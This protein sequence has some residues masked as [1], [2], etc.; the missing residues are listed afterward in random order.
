MLEKMCSSLSGDWRGSTA[1]RLQLAANP[2]PKQFSIPCALRIWNA[3][4]IK[5]HFAFKYLCH[6][7]IRK[8]C[9]L[10]EPTTDESQWIWMPNIE[11]ELSIRSIYACMG[12][13]GNNRPANEACWH[14]KWV[15]GRRLV[16]VIA[17]Q[18][19]R[20]PKRIDCYQEVPFGINPHAKIHIV[21]RSKKKK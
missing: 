20:W 17:P 6:E 4:A 2:N 21:R 19:P 13:P 5:C 18:R 15:V 11:C 7:R 10:N 14:D 3:V 16:F 9:I 12:V 1:G 8:Y